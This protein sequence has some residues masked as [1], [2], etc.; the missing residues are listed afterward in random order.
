VWR[1]RRNIVQLFAGTE[2]KIGARGA[3]AS[4]SP[5]PAPQAPPHT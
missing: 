4:P 5:S 3:P 1:H 2:S